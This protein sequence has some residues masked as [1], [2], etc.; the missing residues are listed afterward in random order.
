[1]RRRADRKLPYELRWSVG[2][3]RKS[4]SFLTY[5]LADNYRSKLMVAARAGEE[6]DIEKGEP[7]SWI[8]PE[9]EEE[10]VTWYTHACNYVAMK[11]PHVSA[12]N[13]VSLAGSL[14]TVTP[15]LTM[16]DAD[17]PDRQV[18]RTALFKWAFNRSTESGQQPDQIASV[19]LVGSINS[20]AL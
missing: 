7:L 12:K 19:L 16:T 5:A 11:W 4:C 13:R 9:P 18:L 17:K 3:V 2:G 15:A 20:H 1:I 8:K 10:P 6:F 14:A